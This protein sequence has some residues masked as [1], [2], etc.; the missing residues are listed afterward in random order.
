MGRKAKYEIGSPEW[1]EQHEYS[2]WSISPQGNPHLTIRKYHLAIIEDYN[3]PGKW[4]YR[5]A[6]PDKKQTWSPRKY[7]S[8]D[9]AKRPGLEEVAQM[10]L[11]H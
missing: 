4:R 8:I 6:D 5:I 10:I 1:L 3:E 7:N 9:E 2:T 11:G